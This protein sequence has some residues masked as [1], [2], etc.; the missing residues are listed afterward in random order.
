MRR[1]HYVC[2][3]VSAALCVCLNTS[4]LAAAPSAPLATGLR[5]L[6]AAYDRGD[7]RLPQKLKLHLTDRSGDPL[8]KVRILPG[9]DAKA[10]LAD[11]AAAGFRLQTQST[12]DPA[13]VEGVLPL[14]AAHKAAAVTGVHS[15]HA[16]HRPMKRAGAVQSQAVALQKADLAQKNGFD[17]KGIRIAA[18]SDSYDACAEC[19]THAADDIKSGDLPKAGVTVLPGQDLPV[20]AGEDEGR[21][22]LQLIHDVAPGAQLGF[23]TA[24]IG[25]VEFAENILAL[26]SQFKADVIVDDVGYF[27]EPMYSDGLV[28]KAVNQVAKSGGAY[29]S[30]AGNNGLEAFEDTYNGISLAKAKALVAAGHGNVKLEQIPAA[31]RPQSVHNFGGFDG[32]SITQRV[33]VASDA[34]F[35]F[36]WDEPFNVGG[37]KTDYNIYVFDKDGNWLDPNTAQTVFYTTDDNLQTDQALELAEMIPF[38]TD[39]VGGAN[40]SDYQIVIGSVNGGPAKRIKYV[41][42]NALAVSERQNA[43]STFGHPTATG[44]LGVAAMYYAIPQFPEDFSSPGPVTIYFDQQGKR[45]RTPEVRFT[46]QITAADGVNTTFFIPGDDPDGDGFPNFFGTSA[47]APDAAAVAGLVLQA[48]GGP[49]SLS[50]QQVYRRLEQTATPVWVPNERSV[51]GTIAGPVFFNI[52][53]DWTRWSRDFSVNVPL[54]FGHHSISTITLDTSAIGLTFNTNLNRFSVGDSTGVTFA[55]MTPSVSSDA[56]QFTIKFAPGK[57][58]S[59]DAFDF[60][61]SVFAPIQGSVQED[62][63]RFRGM[64][65]IVT[66]DNGQKWSA[67]V[68][69]LPKLP[70]NNFTGFGLVNADAATRNHGR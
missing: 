53:A 57:L 13:I 65:V 42:D 50:P 58:S 64:N 9:A 31:I 7:P 4:S 14:A 56:K 19:A 25:E 17:G 67:P 6:A 27:D 36:Q 33:S 35:D 47:A 20:G 54:I 24:F 12:L 23:A 43:P 2:A 34:V 48:A 37:V 15:I 21:A 62:P 10:V 39:V 8:V 32:P 66:L 45:L 22:M 49:G 29:F 38:P 61:L 68:L 28:S 51:A 46:P 60:G 44:A 59:G 40:V 3:A 55:D 16:E 63:D 30:S 18:L 11:L 70:I 1:S 41:V 69:A 5:E 26:R 52:N